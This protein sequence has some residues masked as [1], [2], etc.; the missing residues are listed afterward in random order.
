MISICH[1]LHMSI[2]QTKGNQSSNI[3]ICTIY[4]IQI[5]VQLFNTPQLINVGVLRKK[6]Q[7]GEQI[8]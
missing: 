1:L 2:S 4:L 6:S 3:Q 8:L 5:C 7:S